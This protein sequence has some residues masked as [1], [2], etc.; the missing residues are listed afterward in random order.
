MQ[1]PFSAMQA[2]YI[3]PRLD[4]APLH[5]IAFA[6]STDRF[7]R[8]S[9]SRKALIA[10]NPFAGGRQGAAEALRREILSALLVIGAQTGF[11]PNQIEVVSLTIEALKAKLEAAPNAYQRLIAVGGDGTVSQMVNLGLQTNL[12]VGI[13][14]TG[15]GNRLAK[16]LHIPTGKDAAGRRAA[17]A[18]ALTGREKAIDV[19]QVNGQPAVFASHVGLSE[20]IIR[21]TNTHPE[22]KRHLGSAAYLCEALK[23][24]MNPPQ[25]RFRISIDDQRPW[26][27]TAY[28]VAAINDFSFGPFRLA[29]SA[30]I[31]DGKLNLVIIGAD[32]HPFRTL[33]EL[34][35]QNIEVLAPLAG[36]A[37][38]QIPAK[39]ARIEC[40]DARP[41]PID[42][43]GDSGGQ[44]P[45][46]VNIASQQARII[47]PK[48]V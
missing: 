13:V 14:A 4:A 17:L 48:D 15:T 20:C 46:T 23:L 1:A 7:A 44:T 39:K 40:L 22:L 28:A 36:S 31:D 2:P 10:I 19:M 34:M 6:G 33:C 45:L 32:C 9:D 38:I 16:L 11:P 24:C 21:R 8:P 18:I 41:L 30:K 25:N 27:V 12:P 43:D 29:P 35:Q 26:E 5:P 37:V 3:R 47:V 42:I